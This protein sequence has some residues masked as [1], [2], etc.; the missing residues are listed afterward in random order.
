MVTE[1][2]SSSFKLKILKITVFRMHGWISLI[3]GVMLDTGSK[4]GHCNFHK[5]IEVKVTDFEF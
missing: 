3:D 2:S 1:F 4:N 5:D